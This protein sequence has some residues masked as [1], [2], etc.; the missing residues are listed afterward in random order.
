MSTGLV[1]QGSLLRALLAYEQEVRKHAYQLLG[2]G[3]EGSLSVAL[4]RAC[5]SPELLNLH[6]PW[7]LLTTCLPILAMRPGHGR[8]PTRTSQAKG[9]EKAAL[10]LKTGDGNRIC[11]KFN[12]GKCNGCCAY[13]H[14]CQRCL[15][16]GHGKKSCR[17]GE[18]RCP[19]VACGWDDSS[20]LSP[21][22]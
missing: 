15:Q 19:S 6:F 17:T 1:A 8:G 18:K 7:L 11:V 3:D 21:F 12:N 20:A 14:V 13:E 22:E 16:S 5:R 4:A 9:K 2:D 10:K